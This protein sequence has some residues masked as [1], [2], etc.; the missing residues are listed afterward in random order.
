[1]IWRRLLVHGEASLGELHYALQI[2]FGWS[3]EHSHRFRI[4]GKE[5]GIPQPGGMLFSEDARH[6]PLS[7]FRLHCGER[8]RYEYDF[9]AGWKLDLR[10][11]QVLP[12]EPA[13]VLPSCV[14]G[15]R[16]APPEDCGGARD[17]LQ[18][19]DEHRCPFEDLAV[20]AEAVQRLIDSDGDRR[21]IGDLDELRRSVERVEAYQAFQPQRFGRRS[22]NRLL[23]AV[24]AEVSR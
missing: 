16:A 24:A 1:L 23:Q 14:G 6:V 9:T 20:M 13:S 2:V 11:E 21:A 17:Y 19:L 3:D 4:H 10:L 8:F 18:R 22:V 15:K 7:R 5:Y 12:F